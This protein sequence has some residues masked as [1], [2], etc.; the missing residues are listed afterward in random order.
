MIEL[1][2]MLVI[3]HFVVDFLWQPEY[4]WR[5]KGTFGHPGGITHAGL[6]AVVTLIILNSYGSLAFTLA[7]AEGMLH[8]YIDWGKMNI[9]ALLKLTP[10]DPRFWYWL[11]LDQLLH[12]LTYLW[13]VWYIFEYIGK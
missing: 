4:M 2:I 6:H 13:I 3:K 10:D 7:F 12:Y 1:M 9:S 8:Y 5:N 11:G